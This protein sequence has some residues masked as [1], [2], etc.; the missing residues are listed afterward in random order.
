[1]SFLF[2]VFLCGYSCV[3]ILASNIPVSCNAVSPVDLVETRNKLHYMN[4][5]YLSIVTFVFL[6]VPGLYAQSPGGVTPQSF[7]LAKSR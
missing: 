3:D 1:M 2:P 7:T 6:S 5:V 4:K